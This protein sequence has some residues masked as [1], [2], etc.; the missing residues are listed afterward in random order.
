[1]V[2]GEWEAT[3]AKTDEAVTA[4][5]IVATV[6]EGAVIVASRGSSQRRL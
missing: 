5:A 1:M 3:E 4:V 6:A 2:A